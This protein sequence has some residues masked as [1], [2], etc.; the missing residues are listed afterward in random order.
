M[1]C[2]ASP[3]FIVPRIQ[4]L[5]MNEAAR[6]V[7]EGVATAEDIDKAT[8]Y[9]FGFRF[10]ALGLVEFIDFGGLDIL[11]Y[12]GRYLAEATGEARFAPPAIVA[13]NM[14]AGRIGVKSGQGFYDHPK[15]EA[16]A[17]QLAVMG[18]LIDMLKNQN[19]LRAPGAARHGLGDL[20]ETK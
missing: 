12:A 9:G 2:A 17:S 7:E 4:A 1:V 14:E 5:A 3:G 13:R 8:R 19:S 10:A 18:R 20:K 11:Y 6:L 16:Q 15:G